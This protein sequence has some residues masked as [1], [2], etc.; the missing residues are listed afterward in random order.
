TILECEPVPD[1]GRKTVHWE[2]TDRLYHQCRATADGWDRELLLTT[3]M[4]IGF[5]GGRAAARTLLKEGDTRYIALSWGGQNPPLD[6]EDAYSRLV[7]TAHHWQHWI[8]RGNSP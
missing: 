6:Y 2:Y 4:R 7:W 8:A 1:Y 3:D 5:E